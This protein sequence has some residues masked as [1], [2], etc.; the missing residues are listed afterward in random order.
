MC[1]CICVCVHIYIYIHTHT[2]HYSLSCVLGCCIS[3]L[4]VNRT[5]TFPV[6][7]EQRG[8]LTCASM[9]EHQRLQEGIKPICLTV[10]RVQILAVVVTSGSTQHVHYVAVFSIYW[11]FIY[12]LGR[13]LVRWV[14]L[15]A[16]IYVLHVFL[17]WCKCIACCFVSLLWHVLEFVKAPCKWKVWLFLVL[18]KPGDVVLKV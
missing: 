6:K 18:F 4:F 17:L 7:P 12:I 1:V 8:W 16:T 5:E 11:I 2:I 9:A 10:H 3:G 13:I 14:I 15:Y